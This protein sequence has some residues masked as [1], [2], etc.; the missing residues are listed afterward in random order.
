MREFLL[1]LAGIWIVS[2]TLVVV[3][4]TIDERAHRRRSLAAPAV[5]A[6]GAA[7]V[8]DASRSAPGSAPAVA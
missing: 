8:R 7:G 6:P 4:F 2:G 3:M 1:I 5:A